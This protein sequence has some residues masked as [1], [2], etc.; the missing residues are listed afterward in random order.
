ML[1]CVLEIL[2]GILYAQ[3]LTLKSTG[4]HEDLNTSN[5]NIYRLVYV[6]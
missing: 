1:L 3:K 6:Y 5:N 4:P 2:F